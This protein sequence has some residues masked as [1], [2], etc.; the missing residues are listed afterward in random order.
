MIRHQRDRSG[1][2]GAVA[3]AVRHDRHERPIAGF[4]PARVS[5]LGDSHSRSDKA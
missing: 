2:A 5:E 3:L 4:L 1:T